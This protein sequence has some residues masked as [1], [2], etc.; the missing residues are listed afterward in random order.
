M[1]IF[2]KEGE[3][4]DIALE[5]LDAAER[6]VATGSEA[7]LEYLSGDMS[8]QE[9]LQRKVN[10]MEAEADRLRRAIGDKLFSGA[11]MPLMR[12]DIFRLIESIDRVPNAAE[13]C[14]TF[15]YSERP[16]VPEEFREAFIEIT[17]ESFGE[18]EEL[19]KAVKRFFK[20]KGKMDSIREH[21]E[22]IGTH[23]SEV[24]EKELTLTLAI[25][26]SSALELGVKLH[27]R[28]ALSRIVELSDRAEDCGDHLILI[29]LKSVT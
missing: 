1:K 25:F 23:E 22:A 21:V 24:D 27:L 20:P 26:D 16:H 4:A 10:D 17:R 8:R 14:C 15:F 11:Y 19:K 13:A 18:F 5:Y 9:E 6:C 12:G 2:K 29:A 28:K 3:V 7:I